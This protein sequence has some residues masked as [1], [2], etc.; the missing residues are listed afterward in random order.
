MQFLKTLF[1]MTVAVIVAIASYQNWRS[2]SIDLWGGLLVDVKLPVLVLGAFFVGL[3]PGLILNRTT[4]WRLGRRLDSSERA[5]AELRPA[6]PAV[7]TD[8][9]PLPSA[10]LPTPSA[11]P[12]L[13]P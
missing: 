13:V 9:D 11:A 7:T 6:E 4:Q 5:L 8:T 2:V 3:I 10:P 1:W 12:P